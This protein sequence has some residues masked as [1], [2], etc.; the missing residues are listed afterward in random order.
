MPNAVVLTEYGPPDVLE[1]RHVPMP[2]P[3]PGQVRLR[4][5]AAGS[6]RAT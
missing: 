1:W 6:A 2:D 3:G 4:V 5:K